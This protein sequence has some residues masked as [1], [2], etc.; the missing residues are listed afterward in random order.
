MCGGGKFNFGYGEI[1]LPLK[2]PNAIT[3]EKEGDKSSEVRS[4]LWDKYILKVNKTTC[5]NAI[6]KGEGT[7]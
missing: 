1:Q 3:T 6:A 4:A 5:V 7:Q 2:Y